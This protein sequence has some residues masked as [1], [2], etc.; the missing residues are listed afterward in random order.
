[1]RLEA[2]VLAHSGRSCDRVNRNYCSK[3]LGNDAGVGS[4]S[5]CYGA[6]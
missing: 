3:D 1:M 6:H 5:R 4:S 2:E